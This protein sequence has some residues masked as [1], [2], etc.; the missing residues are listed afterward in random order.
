VAFDPRF[1]NT[2]ATVAYNPSS[3]LVRLE[4][5]Y[6]KGATPKPGTYY[7]IHVLDDILYAHQ[8]HPFTLAYKSEGAHRKE[9]VQAPS[10][11]L[12]SHRFSSVE[13]TESDPL[14][15]SASASRAAPSLV[16]LI[17]PYDGFTSRLAQKALT[18]PRSIHVLVDGPYGHTVPLRQYFH[19]LFVVGGT[20]IA[21]PLSHLAS[22][23]SNGSVVTSLRIVWAVREY[24]F[25]ASVLN[26]FHALLQD[27][28]VRLE[29]YVTQDE[30]NE[31]TV[32]AG[33]FKRVKIEA[34]RPDVHVVVAEAAAEADRESLA[35]MACGPAQMADQARHAS[36]GMLTRGF[37]GI[38]YFEESFK[39]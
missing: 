37:R 30:E 5:T 34:G 38:E 1:W 9:Q 26:E 35:I 12:V 3:H 14:L 11:R 16:F 23:L 36:V 6:R 29:A 7:Y 10:Q 32:V 2:K 18:N 24:E 4:V 21:V 39:W 19:V 8:S 15:G 20:G 17:R 31:D 22:I 27:E 33:E 28:R 13:P 25:L